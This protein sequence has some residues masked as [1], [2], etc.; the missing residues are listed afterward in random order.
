MSRGARG[1]LVVCAVC[2]AAPAR[3]EEA[4]RLPGA[5]VQAEYEV[6]LPVVGGV[7]PYVW[8]LA[9]GA[10]PEGLGLSESGVL[11]GVPEEPGR[12]LFVVLVED[13]RAE[14]ARRAFSLGVDPLQAD[15]QPLSL[16]ASELP[17]AVTGRTYRVVLPVTG[18]VPPYTWTVVRGRLPPGLDLDEAGEI[19]GMPASAGHRAFTLEVRDSQGSPSVARRDANIRVIPAATPA[20]RTVRFFLGLLLFLLAAVAILTA[21]IIRLR[22]RLGVAHRAEAEARASASAATAAAVKTQAL[23][24]ALLKLPKPPPKPRKPTVPPKTSPKPGRPPGP[25]KVASALAGAAKPPA[26]APV[27]PAK[28]PSNVTGQPRGAP[29]AACPICGAR[30]SLTV[31]LIPRK[32][33]RCDKCEK[34]FS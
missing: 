18:G 1:V 13:S 2:L 12:F 17:E 23:L 11:A 3:G 20:T 22:S 28:P 25:P 31:I 10:L 26:N 21:W 8:S 24:A 19:S 4:R 9:E 29:P 7:P 6:V 16:L 5:R 33:I 14:V 15:L 30:G 32:G 27:S 34:V